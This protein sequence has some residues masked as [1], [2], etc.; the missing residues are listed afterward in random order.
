MPEHILA[1]DDDDRILRLVQI[2]LERAGYRI[3][4]ASDGVEALEQLAREPPDLVLLDITM[5]RMD[6]MEALRRLRAA[7]ETAA[8]P[9]V[10]LTAK[11]QDEDILEGRRSGADYYLHKPFSPAELIAVVREALGDA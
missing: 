10:L 8:I 7:P 3:S 5:P 2:N 9:V 11:A 6:G 1:V 4:T